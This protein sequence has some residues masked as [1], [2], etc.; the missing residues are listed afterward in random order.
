MLQNDEGNEIFIREAERLVNRKEYKGLIPVVETSAHE[1]INVDH[2]F[3]LG[4]QTT[5]YLL[6]GFAC[7][8]FSVIQLFSWFPILPSFN[9][10]ESSFDDP[11][12]KHPSD[13]LNFPLLPPAGPPQFV[14]DYLGF[15]TW[16]CVY[17]INPKI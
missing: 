4:K 11:E 12:Q 2:A 5:S 10:R 13:R 14:Y 16:F 17:V 8:I 3:F 7:Q 6:T 9:C 1:N 15:I